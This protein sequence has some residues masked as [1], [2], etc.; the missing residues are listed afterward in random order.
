MKKL[1]I[2][3]FFTLFFSEMQAQKPLFN[4]PMGVQAY[5][6][7]KHFP[8][9]VIGTLDTIKMFGITELETGVP[10]GLTAEEFRKLCD[11]RGIAIPSTGSGFDQLEKNPADL[12]KDAK[13]LGVKFVMCAWIPHKKGNFNLDDA[14]KAV[15][16]FNRAGKILK[17]SGLTFC[18][19]D[20]GF[21]FQP[22]EKGTLFDYIVENTN[23]DYVS[24]EMDVLWTIHG[25]ADPVALLKKYK[26]RWKLMHVKDLKKG[27]KGDFTG[28]TPAEND[29]VLG[30]GQADWKKILKVAKKVG[31]EHYFLEDESNLEMENVPKSIAYLKGLK[32]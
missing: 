32:K 22:Y 30:E 15:A 20:H 5:T 16:V 10:K 26:S 4:F 28:G 24:F 3:G 14:K 8:N 17:D 18:Y 12:V 19:H 11:E 31:I 6:F 2:L 1:I 25:G 27:I 29:V 23:P 21:E 9:N 7:R 13:I